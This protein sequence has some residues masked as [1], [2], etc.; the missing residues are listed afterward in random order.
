MNAQEF[1]LAPLTNR[2]NNLSTDTTKFDIYIIKFEVLMMQWKL[3]TVTLVISLFHD[4][5]KLEDDNNV[6]NILNKNRSL[7]KKKNRKPVRNN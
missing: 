7:S 3:Q 5:N 2:V 6:N 1:E 4:M